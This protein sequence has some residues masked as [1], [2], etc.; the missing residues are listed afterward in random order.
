MRIDTTHLLLC[1][2]MFPPHVGI[3]DS[4]KRGSIV[5]RNLRGALGQ[6]LPLN[7]CGPPKAC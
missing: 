7:T 2:K 5:A 3:E 4:L 6:Q 1:Q